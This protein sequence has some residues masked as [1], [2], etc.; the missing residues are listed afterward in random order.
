[1][2]YRTFTRGDITAFIFN[3]HIDRETVESILADDDI[4]FCRY[5]PRQAGGYFQDTWHFI[6]GSRTAA[7]LIRSYDI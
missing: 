2:K 7:Y 1:M 6:Q 3:G 4:Q 5:A